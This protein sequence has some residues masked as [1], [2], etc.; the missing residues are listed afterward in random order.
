[1]TRC[2][3]CFPGGPV[4]LTLTHPA[5]YEFFS[6]YPGCRSAR[7]SV[8]N[9]RRMGCHLSH[10]RS[11]YA[12]CSNGALS[13]NCH[14]GKAGAFRLTYIMFCRTQVGNACF[15]RRVNYFPCTSSAFSAKCV[16]PMSRAAPISL[17]YSIM[18]AQKSD[19]LGK[20]ITL[21]D[22]CGTCISLFGSVPSLQK[23]TATQE[24]CA[25]GEPR[26]HS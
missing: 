16:R 8:H 14:V 11:K 2:E 6:T 4:T 3:G 12:V 24:H 25:P 10:P 19:C 21:I 23:Q 22:G 13:F 5:F 26:V 15:M 9:L 1:M 20:S 7:V 18:D 17:S